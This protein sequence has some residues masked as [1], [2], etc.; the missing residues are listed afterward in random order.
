MKFSLL[1]Y[2]INI[3]VTLTFTLMLVACN[4]S[5]EAQLPTR[6]FAD[7]YSL[8]DFNLNDDYRYW[9]IRQGNSSY[10]KAGHT[11]LQK[12]DTNKH[13]TLTSDQISRLQKIN[14]DNGYD[15]TCRPEY[16]PI[17]GVAVLSDSFFTIESETD[18]ITF[19]DE[20]D[21]EAELYVYLSKSGSQAKT[22]EKNGLGYKALVSWDNY[23]GTRGEN[24]VQVF[25]DGTVEVIREISVSE[26]NGCY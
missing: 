16:C 5:E 19:F 13:S 21:T 6:S 25:T 4:S 10:Q 3:S 11:V 18:L 20:I 23:C 2:I 15:S 14:V 9:E 12:F 1:K 24:L 7:S 26:Y 22:Y 17:Y 8:T